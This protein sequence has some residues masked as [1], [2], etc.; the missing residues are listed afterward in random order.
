MKQKYQTKAINTLCN[1]L[2]DKQNAFAISQ[3]VLLQL[4][5]DKAQ[6]SIIER[7]IAK[8]NL[9]HVDITLLE[10]QLDNLIIG[11]KQLGSEIVCE[12]TRQW[13]PD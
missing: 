13:I 1:T 10:K 3:Q 7:E 2:E 5:K 6:N 4:I 11:K 9:L 8:R 12:S